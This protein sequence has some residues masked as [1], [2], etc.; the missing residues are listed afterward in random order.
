[1]PWA[2]ELSNGDLKNIG[3]N[4]ILPIFANIS[5]DFGG[6]MAKFDAK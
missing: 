1:M 2:C 3:I 6:S 4:D 5:I